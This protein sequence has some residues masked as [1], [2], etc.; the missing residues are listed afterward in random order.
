MLYHEA[1]GKIERTDFRDAADLIFDFVRYGNKYYDTER[2][3]E[4]RHANPNT[5]GNTLYNCV[6]IVAN[7]AVLLSPFLPFSSKKLRGWL[8]LREAWQPQFVPYGF[9]IPSPELLF[10]RL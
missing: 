4:T 3:W 5:C 8:S 6:Q 9:K 2:P 1:G 7:L 10:V